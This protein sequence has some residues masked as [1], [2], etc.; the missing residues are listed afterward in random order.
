MTSR[1]PAAEAGPRSR[2]VRLSVD[3]VTATIDV[4]QCL[5]V[6]FREH[7]D[8]VVH[9]RLAAFCAQSGS[10]PVCGAPALVDELGLRALILQAA[11]TGTGPGRE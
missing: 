1:P 9:A 8:S 6:F 7:A 2:E 5:D 11:L 3:A 10:D 4:L